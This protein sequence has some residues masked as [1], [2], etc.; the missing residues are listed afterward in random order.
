MSSILDTLSPDDRKELARKLRQWRDDPVA[1]VREV[2]GTEPDEW[3]VDALGAVAVNPR[4]AMSACKG[5]GKSAMLAWVIWWFLL[6]RADAQILCASITGPN[7]RDG[8]WKELARWGAKS[9]LLSGLFDVSG[10]RITSKESP[11][12]W[13]C[14]ARSW[15]Q[16]A[17]AT[18]QANTLAGFHGEHVMIAL[19][20]IGDYP[21]GV[22]AAAEGIFANIGVEAKLVCAGNPTR[23]DG[24]LYRITTKDR[25]RWHVVTITGDPDDPKRSPRI[26]IEN[27]RAV[28][29]SLGRDH[30]W[31]RVNILGQFPRV[32]SDML[33]GPDDVLAAEQ[34]ACL[35]ADFQSEPIIFGLDVARMGDDRT[36]LVKR[37][38]SVSF[39]PWVWRK[40]DGTQ[41]GDAVAA[42]LREEADY[43]YLVIDL[44]GPGASVYDRLRVLGFE[45]T[46]IGIDFGG[47][48]LDERYA[49]RGTEAWFVMADW[50]RK[51]AC[52]PAGDGEMAAEL[53]SRR[54]DFKLLHKRTSFI[55][56][57]KEVMRRKG[58]PSPD[59]A[60]ALALTFAAPL[61]PRFR[62]APPGTPMAALYQ[63]VEG[64][65][66]TED[67][68]PLWR[69]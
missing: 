31:V 46:M 42:I 66:R 63:Q 28:I 38:G 12:T 54:Y 39:R 13:W 9:Q 50:V 69:D 30:D 29:E 7:L 41:V 56:E 59:K 6:T 37:Q 58:L 35:P 45:D 34:R 43:D 3:Q 49:N 52:L 26:D 68:G 15:A 16:D 60:D 10:E 18:Q 55:L 47:K 48:P 61:G 24:P 5:P 20:E 19:D 21:N 4:V 65:Y 1:F 36:V 51:R 57:S 32:S 14:S 17:D 23:V 40:M 27:A 8:L 64:R 2:L 67:D 44:G 53:T 11:R 25:P 62:R 33:L 22:L